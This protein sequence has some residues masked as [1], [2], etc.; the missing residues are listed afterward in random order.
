LPESGVLAYSLSVIGPDV[1]KTV[2]I[3]NSQKAYQGVFLFFACTGGISN[4]RNPLRA[5]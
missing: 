3:I 4:I 5:D 2:N 1:R